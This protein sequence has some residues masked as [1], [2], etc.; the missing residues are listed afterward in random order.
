MSRQSNGISKVIRIINTRGAVLLFY[1][2]IILLLLS[3]VKYVF[4]AERCAVIGD[5]IAEGIQSYFPECRHNTKIGISTPAII[6]RMRATGTTAELVIISAG[7]NDADSFGLSRQLPVNLAALRA[8]ASGRVV[9]IAPINARASEAV[10][11]IADS[12]KDAIASF[13]PGGDKV[14]PRNN[15]AL[16]SV[17]RI[18]MKGQ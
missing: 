10:R 4:S 1:T 2:A 16:A 15:A 5:S 13:A 12:H 14:H 9:W 6:T 17:I 7:S 11:S 3:Q 18:M 8:L